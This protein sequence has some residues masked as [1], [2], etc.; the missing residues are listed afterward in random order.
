MRLLIVCVLIVSSM[1]SCSYD[2]LIAS[3]QSRKAKASPLEQVNL[4]ELV[5]RYMAKDQTS[6]GTLEGIYSV[7]SVVTK[8][9]KAV[10]SAREKER[11]TDRRE[12]YSKIA[13]IRD[14]SEA[15]REFIE[16]VLDKEYQS[17]YPVYGEFSTMAES[18]LMLY[19]HFDSKARSSSYTFTY[20]K[21][22]DVLEGVRT[23]NANNKTITYK[24]T[25]VKL[26]P[27]AQ[28]LSAR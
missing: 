20:D 17:S 11:I 22:K 25:Y 4:E 24:L 18:N 12:N 5:E 10:F 7:S 16:I 13:I 19:K 8:K 27:K 1:S 28:P 23:D 26:A 14:N 15:G 3:A 2:R 9:G 21:S 6:I